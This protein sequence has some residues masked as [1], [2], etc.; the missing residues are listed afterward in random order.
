MHVE[1]I[2]LASAEA[3]ARALAGRPGLAWLDG[4]GSPTEGRFSYVAS[5]PVEH[6]VRTLGDARPLEALSGL[7]AGD[8]VTGEAPRAPRWIGYI[9]YDAAWAGPVGT[10]RDW[11][12]KVPRIVREGAAQVLRFAR[13]DAIVAIEHECAEAWLI[14]DDAEACGRLRE[15]L[16][17]GEPRALDYAVRDVVAP[18]GAAH[19]AAVRSA[20]EH[21]RAGDIYQVNL[22]RRWTAT[23]EGA[24]REG[25]ALGLY[26]AMRRASAVPLGFFLDAGDHAVLACTMERFLD[27]DGRTLITRPIKGTLARRGGDD[28]REAATLRAD[29][30][31]QAEHTMIVDLMRNDLGRVA[32][33]GSVRVE[34]LLEVEPYARLSHL[35][36]TVTCGTREGTTLGEVLEATFPPG[37]VTGA[38]KAR[39]MELIEELEPVPRGVYC[40]ALGFVDR[41]GGVSLAVA[42]RTAVARAGS[43]VYHAG[44]GLVVASDP[45]RE[46]AETELKARAFLDAVGDFSGSRGGAARTD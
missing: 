23:L 33:V 39:A 31:E 13:Y 6:C 40:G 4:D 3:A 42:I 25:A 36:S 46:L 16:S 27:W 43:V 2:A 30:K 20:L 15:R 45:E 17:K 41:A 11:T 7:G 44:G 21:I 19:L 34:R 38:P 22:A 32:K 35:V 14:G 8:E 26:L 12:R 1:R 29:P 24:S 5:D 9:A 10:Q 37:S 28:A 18:P